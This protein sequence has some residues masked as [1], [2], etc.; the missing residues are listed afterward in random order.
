MTGNFLVEPC[1]IAYE[2]VFGPYHGWAD[3]KAVIAALQELPSRDL[4]LRT[5]KEDGTY[6]IL[7]SIFS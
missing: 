5:I 7:R 4:L 6:S 1:T 2:Q 3:K